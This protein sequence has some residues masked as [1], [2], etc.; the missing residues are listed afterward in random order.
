MHAVGKNEVIEKLLFE[1]CFQYEDIITITMTS[2]EQT[3]FS[4]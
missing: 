4:V 2:P 1:N 3:I